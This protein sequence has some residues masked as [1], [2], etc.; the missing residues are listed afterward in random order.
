MNIINNAKEKAL[1]LMAIILVPANDD[2]GEDAHKI[3]AFC[4]KY[5]RIAFLIL[6]SLWGL[7]LV[8]FVY[9]FIK[10]GGPDPVMIAKQAEFDKEYAETKEYIKAEKERMNN[11]WF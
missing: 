7:S 3:S 6:M 9:S 10:Y 4:R 11:S 1:D 8:L 5:R 2:E